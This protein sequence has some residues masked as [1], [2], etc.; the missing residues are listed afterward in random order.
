MGTNEALAEVVAVP[1]LRTHACPG[2]KFVSFGFFGLVWV[3]PN[4]SY[5]VAIRLVA[6]LLL[7]WLEELQSAT[8]RILRSLRADSSREKEQNALA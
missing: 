8:S 5:V 3:H 6:L 2:M 7:S 4:H 1:N